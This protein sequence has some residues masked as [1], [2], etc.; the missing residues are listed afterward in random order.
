MYTTDTRKLNLIDKVLKVNSEELLTKI[1]KLLKSNRDIPKDIPVA[2]ISDFAG[3]LSKKEA[4]EMKEAINMTCET[5]DP[6]VWK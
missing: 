4:K 5:I 1:E 3:F 2:N 6:D